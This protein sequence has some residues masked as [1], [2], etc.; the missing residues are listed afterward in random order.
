MRNTTIDDVPSLAAA[1]LHSH[2]P[3]AFDF[4]E[5][6]RQGGYGGLRRKRG[7]VAGRLLA[8]LSRQWQNVEG[9]RVSHLL[10]H[11]RGHGASSAQDPGERPS[12][13]RSRADAVQRISAVYLLE[14]HTSTHQNQRA[15]FGIIDAR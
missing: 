1:A 13:S 11:K 5:T 12:C 9:R 15:D 14:L 10:R 7:G 8:Y 2:F 6:T 4:C 3:V